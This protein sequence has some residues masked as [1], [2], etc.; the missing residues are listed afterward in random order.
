MTALPVEA[1]VV[2]WQSGFHAGACLD[3][4]KR[5]GVENV[6]AVDNASSD[7]TLA[8]L[9][10]HLPQERILAMP[11]NLGF[12]GA[13]NTGLERTRAPFVLLLNP[14]AELFPGALRALLEDAR[15]HPQAGL[16][17][18]LLVDARD[19]PCWDA[20]RGLPGLLDRLLTGS[21]CVSLFPSMAC[22]RRD[23][24][25][26]PATARVVPALSGACLLVS[27]EALEQV[28]PL[29]AG[30]FLY[31]EDLDWCLRMGKAGRPCRFVPSA[32]VR[33]W[34]GASAASAWGRS[35]LENRRS[36]LRYFR[37]H[38]GTLAVLILQA[39]RVLDGFLRILLD[40][41]LLPLGERRGR[42]VYDY[43]RRD[44]DAFLAVLDT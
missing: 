4:L 19:K 18:P 34:G 26:T 31:F 41:A 29:D 24:L 25:P 6:I 44:L 42:P 39:F 43:L 23:L 10:A 7:G 8:C 13:A 35:Y 9:R 28:G 16:R 12:A 20:A 36:E 1:V 14:D 15:E 2:T 32:K 33:H 22:M 27:R 11:R 40:L 21:L 38:Q 5:E 17:G 3:S 30:F 37:K